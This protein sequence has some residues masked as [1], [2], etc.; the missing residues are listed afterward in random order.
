MAKLRNRYGKCVQCLKLA[1]ALVCAGGLVACT[2][3]PIE[4]DYELL[5]R[6]DRVGDCARLFD[7]VDGMVLTHGVGDAQGQRVSGFPHLRVNRLLG[8]FD[9]EAMDAETFDAWA[10]E[11]AVL[12]RRARGFELRNLPARTGIESVEAELNDCRMVLRQHDLAQPERRRRLIRRA[13]ARDSYDTVLRVAGLYPLSAIPVGMGIARLHADAEARFRV[14]LAQLPRRGELVRFAPVTDSGS[15]AA[16]D[17]AAMLAA[18]DN[19]LRLPRPS[20]DHLDRLFRTFAPV[21]EVD[22]VSDD[23]RIGSPGFE[24]Q[25]ARVDTTRPTAFTLHSYAR[26]DG[27]FVL[28]LGYVVWFPSRPLSGPFD[29][30]G[31]HI[32]GLT[33]RVTLAGDGRPLFY[34]VMHNC[35]CFH[36]AFPTEA[37][38]PRPHRA[39]EE[40]VLSPQ[41]LW[42]DARRPVIRLAARTHYVE[43]VYPYSDAT[44]RTAVTYEL[45]PYDRLRSLPA[46]SGRRSLFAADGIVKGT[47]RAE[48]WLLW[49]MGVPEPGA[50][51]QWGNHAIA[52]VGR[53]HFDDPGLIERNFRRAEAGRTF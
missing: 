26:V 4:P 32:D 5:E 35:G 19:P 49:P 36:M 22:V 30:L 25:E 10:G 28:Q 18:T 13:V 12:D 45:R 53:R 8:S 48:R 33:W 1:A 27:E 37:L 52:F 23:D 2:G 15:L 44:H 34:D 24:D 14:P 47:E 21:F 43:R 6:E 42:R 41:R 29:L 11:L 17:I 46:G 9:A 16:T 39:F 3:V 20:A 38:E 51:R 50:M 40:P 7:R 31:G